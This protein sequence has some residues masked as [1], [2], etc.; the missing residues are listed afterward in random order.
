MTE[1]MKREF[2]R[3]HAP[4]WSTDG[5]GT[6]ICPHGHRVED[7]GTCPEGCESPMRGAGII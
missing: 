4:D 6:L 3:E 7:D 2:L 1:S 5:M